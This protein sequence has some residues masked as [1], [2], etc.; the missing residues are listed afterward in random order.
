M[1]L[2]TIASIA[3]AFV[4]LLLGSMV[5]GSIVAEVVSPLRVLLDVASSMSLREIASDVLL[6]GGC[7]GFVASVLLHSRNQKGDRS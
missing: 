5:L 3:A 6:V 2:G 1:G 4:G 7:A